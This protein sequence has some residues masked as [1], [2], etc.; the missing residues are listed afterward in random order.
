MS[1]RYSYN[2]MNDVRQLLWS[3]LVLAI[4]IIQKLFIEMKSLNNELIGVN[5]AT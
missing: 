1:K 5:A 3:P 4:L 2:F